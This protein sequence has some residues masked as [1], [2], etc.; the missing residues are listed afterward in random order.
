MAG[1]GTEES[2]V[3]GMLCEDASGGVRPVISV[4]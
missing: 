1:G 4:G 2:R 3:G